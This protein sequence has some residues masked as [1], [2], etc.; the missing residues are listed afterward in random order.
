MPSVLFL[1][2]FGQYKVAKN[3]KLEYN[4]NVSTKG[5]KHVNTYICDIKTN[6]RVKLFL[7][8]D[9]FNIVIGF[10]CY[11]DFVIATIKPQGPRTAGLFSA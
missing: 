1:I 9:C 10:W 8:V 2:M 11:T 4:H 5:V 6:K 7:V 3:S